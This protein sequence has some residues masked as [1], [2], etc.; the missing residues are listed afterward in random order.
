MEHN[1]GASAPSETMKAEDEQ[2]AYGRSEG[3]TGIKT[4]L[5]VKC[6]RTGQRFAGHPEAGQASKTQNKRQ[7][8]G[9]APHGGPAERRIR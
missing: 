7:P 1:S 8:G 4:A 2:P 9:K 3:E 6:A 5:K